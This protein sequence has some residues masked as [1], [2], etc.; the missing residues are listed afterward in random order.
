V[1]QF[2][3]P[4]FDSGNR[5]GVKQQREAQLQENEAQLTGQ[6][7]EA[8]AEIRRSY[9]NVRRGERVLDSSRAAAAQAAQVL[10]ITQVS[11]RAGAATNLDVIDAQRRSR[12]AD[13]A[14]AIAEDAVRQARLDL[15]TALGRFPK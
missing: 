6:L 13:T 5:R 9:E 10:D 14:V 7:R 11:F 12:D 8:K 2:G 15:L 4:V 3:V 1:V